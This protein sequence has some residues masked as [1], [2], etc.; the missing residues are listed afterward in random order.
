M[1]AILYWNLSKAECVHTKMSVAYV[2]A[3]IVL[4]FN[5]NQTEIYIISVANKHQGVHLV[6]LKACNQ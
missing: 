6:G 3:S 1:A 4:Y 5:N 2:V